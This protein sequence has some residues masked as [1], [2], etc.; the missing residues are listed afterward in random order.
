MPARVSNPPPEGNPSG[1][2]DPE[3]SGASALLSGRSAAILGASALIA[4]CAGI[5]AYLALGRFPAD[6][7]G[8]VL[9]G[10][11]A[12]AGAVRLLMAIVA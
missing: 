6:L 5:L 7:A 3:I 12:F 11:T 2:P 8:A 9:A 1:E 4:V 10:G